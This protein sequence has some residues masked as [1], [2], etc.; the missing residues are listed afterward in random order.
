MKPDKS[1]QRIVSFEL[2]QRI[3]PV[4]SADCSIQNFRVRFAKINLCG[5]YTHTHTHTHT[6]AR[7]QHTHTKYYVFLIAIYICKFIVRM[8]TLKIWVLLTPLRMK[9]RLP[10]VYFIYPCSGILWRI[11]SVTNDKRPN[12]HFVNNASKNMKRIIVLPI[13]LI[14]WWFRCLLPGFLR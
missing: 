7:T 9:A 13:S 12:S 4:N 3:H 10:F 2:V 5:R 14:E 1:R 6:H 8:L 11:Y